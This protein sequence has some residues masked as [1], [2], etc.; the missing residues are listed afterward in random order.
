M[1]GCD[2]H[3]FRIGNL[4]LELVQAR[5][6][7][8]L[9]H[10]PLGTDLD[11]GIAN[12]LV[13]IEIPPVVVATTTATLTALCALA[14]TAESS[15][16]TAQAL[17]LGAL[18]TLLTESTTASTLVGGRLETS[19]L[20]LGSR[21]V[22]DNRERSLILGVLVV[23]GVGGVASEGDICIW[24]CVRVDRLIGGWLKGKR[25]KAG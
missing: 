21:T 11:R 9:E 20:L 2:L 18:L 3:I 1:L 13:A 6:L 8:L 24:E 17:E 7:N 22:V 16:V 10:V 15:T 23:E 19:G 5:K 14:S 12:A 4:E 25:G